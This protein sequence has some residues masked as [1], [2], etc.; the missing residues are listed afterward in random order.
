MSLMLYIDIESI[1]HH[2]SRRLILC[3]CWFLHKIL[4][5]D[6]VWNLNCRNLPSSR[7][8]LSYYVKVE[9]LFD[10]FM[11]KLN[12]PRAVVYVCAQYCNMN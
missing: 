11:G 2:N 10:S 6:V 4:Q 7:Y 9:Y 5:S 1:Y 8:R 3:N 12:A